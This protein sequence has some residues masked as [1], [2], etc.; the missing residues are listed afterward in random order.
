MLRAAVKAGTPTGKEADAV[1]KAGGLVSDEIVI[2]LINE[3][4]D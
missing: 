3:N 4:M 1:M 2:N